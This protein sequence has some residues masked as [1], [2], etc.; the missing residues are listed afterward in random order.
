MRMK[1]SVHTGDDGCPY[2]ACLPTAPPRIS[3]L[4]QLGANVTEQTEPQTDFHAIAGDQR[5]V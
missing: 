4:R 2:T 5:I 1:F 3:N